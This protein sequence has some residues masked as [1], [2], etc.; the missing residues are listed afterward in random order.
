MEAPPTSLRTVDDP[1]THRQYEV[2][3]F[4]EECPGRPLIVHLGLGSTVLTSVGRRYLETHAEAVSGPMYHLHARA[5]LSAWPNFR[6]R[7]CSDVAVADT[8]GLDRFNVSGISSGAL[9]ALD[10][11][12][13]ADDRTDIAVTVSAPGTMRGYRQYVKAMPRQL[14][15]GMMEFFAFR[16]QAYAEHFNVGGSSDLFRP[17]S[18]RNLA[19]VAHR[20]IRASLSERVERLSPGTYWV[21]IVGEKDALTDYRDHEDLV[22][23]RN[24]GLE[25]SSTLYIEPDQA[26]MWAARPRELAKLVARAIEASP[27]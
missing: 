6:S 15:D 10:M 5:P 18:Y 20:V 1:I 7:A 13:E 27:S 14:I 19:V 16:R 11:A 9:A 23:R 17:R 4:N 2:Y 24:V 22:W 25:E 8:I 12:A 26:H 3:G 21:D